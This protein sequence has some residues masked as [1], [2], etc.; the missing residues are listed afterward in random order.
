MYKKLLREKRSF[1]HAFVNCAIKCALSTGENSAFLSVRGLG[2]LKN[3][4]RTHA[5]APESC[6]QEKKYFLSRL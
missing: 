5:A 2:K 1:L 4:P 6:W 3:F